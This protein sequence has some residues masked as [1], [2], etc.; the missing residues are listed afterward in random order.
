MNSGNYAL[1]MVNGV[2]GVTG[3]IVPKHAAVEAKQ[4]R[5]NAI[6]LHQLMAEMIVLVTPN[7]PKIAIRKLVQQQ[8]IKYDA[9]VRFTIK[10]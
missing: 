4:E 3:L 2:S 10:K 8:V 5:E 6:I 9:N 1:L 7:R